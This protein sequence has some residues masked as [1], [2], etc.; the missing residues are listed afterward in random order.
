MPSQNP[1]ASLRN[2]E[3]RLSQF[4]EYIRSQYKTADN[5][6]LRLRI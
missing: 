1:K 3:L 4:Y 2:N 6:I 5:Y